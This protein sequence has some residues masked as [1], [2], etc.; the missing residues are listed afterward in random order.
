MSHSGTPQPVACALVS[1]DERFREAV[2]EL[3]RGPEP[4]L[5]VAVEVAAPFSDV[6]EAQV[7]EIREAEPELIVLD[8]SDEPA[9]GIRFARFVGEALPGRPILA[10]GPQL[11]SEMLLA[12]MS[13]G[14][15][16][17]LPR[18][19]ED[20]ALRGAVARI[21]RRMGAASGAPR[22]P[23]Q[24]LS[25][26]SVKGGSGCT[27]VAANLAVQL[28]KLTGKKT[29]LL[30]LELEL[31][32]LAVHLGMQPRFNLV[33]LVR[34]FHR[35]DADLLAGYIER[36]DS[37][38]HLLSA[39]VHPERAE[40]VTADQMRTILR[41]LR[42][43]YDYVVVDSARSF[44][45]AN[46]A[47]LEQADRVFLVATVDLPS[48]RNIKRSLP[49]LDRLTGQAAEKVKLVVNRYQS[50]DPISLEEVERTLGM[51]VYRTLANDYE[52]ASRAIHTGQPA[53]TGGSSPFARDLKELGAMVAGIELSR[54]GR[55]FGP[56]GKLFGRKEAQAHA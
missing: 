35:M 25:V 2:H 3:A 12:A 10:A 50:S 27:T 43:H 31:G 45:P 39:P 44:A 46:T 8:L 36:H 20:G 33:D 29:L 34:N 28:H 30:D 26:F 14:V 21:R 4:P 51:E 41:F 47:A 54:N 38:V 32:E 13:A 40:T 52:A 7:R 17:Y 53:V 55:R 24:L 11:S 18:P 19:V 48:L 22:A 42:N 37:G 5:R 49:L 15:S 9:T 56:L 6:R 1:E 23:G 16:E